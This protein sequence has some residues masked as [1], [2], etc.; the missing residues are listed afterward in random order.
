MVRNCAYHNI[1]ERMGS[2]LECCCRKLMVLNGPE[3]LCLILRIAEVW[4]GRTLGLWESLAA[5]NCRN[6]SDWS[7][8]CIFAGAVLCID[9]KGHS[10][11][12]SSVPVNFPDTSILHDREGGFT[13]MILLSSMR[14]KRL[15]PQ[16]MT[17]QHSCSIA[18]SRMRLATVNRGLWISSML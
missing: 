16:G 3:D 5:S 8:G 17:N 4:I 11:T 6:M 10:L 2:T 15:Q 1:D 12:L 18:L 13:R 9:V 7:Y 14:G